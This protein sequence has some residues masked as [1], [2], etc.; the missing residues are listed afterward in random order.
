MAHG[1]FLWNELMTRDVEAVC[2]F[3]GELMGWTY[4]SKPN[5]DGSVYIVAHANGKPVAGIFDISGESLAHLPPHW[6]S[7]I[8]VDDVDEL[9]A[10]ALT[11]GATSIRPPHDVPGIGR[12]A[13]LSDPTGAAIG[14]WKPLPTAR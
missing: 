2:R 11:M 10:R 14:W 6:F 13:Y 7:Y 5:G 12:I 4:E 1:D 9:Y 3:Y 8:G